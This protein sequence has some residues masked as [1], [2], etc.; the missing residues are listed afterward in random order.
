[1]A[2]KE[3]DVPLDDE[4]AGLVRLAQ[5]VVAVE[6]DR[7]IGAVLDDQRHVHFDDLQ[8]VSGAAPAHCPVADKHKQNGVP[9]E[10]CA[11]RLIGGT[12]IRRPRWLLGAP[13]S[14]LTGETLIRRSHWLPAAP[15]CVLPLRR[16][17]TL[18]IG[19]RAS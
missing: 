6:D 10:S 17:S 7:R 8:H 5:R 16:R 13:L 2:K 9:G 1:M 19:P 4:F 3:D 11:S 18:L 12:P 15:L 14:R